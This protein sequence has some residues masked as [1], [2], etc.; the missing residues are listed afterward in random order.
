MKNQS[1]IRN[2]I[3]A[4]FACE[5][6][7]LKCSPTL[8]DSVYASQSFFLHLSGTENELYNRLIEKKRYRIKLELIKRYIKN[9]T[10]L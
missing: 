1:L 4:H 8:E 2:A 7:N 3:T 6:N 10:K 9:L 5:K